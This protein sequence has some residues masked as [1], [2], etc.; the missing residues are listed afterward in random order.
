M[1]F[2]IITIFV[3][4]I[5]FSLL[6]ER[7]IKDRLPVYLIIGLLLVLVSAFKVVGVDPDSDNYEYTFLHYDASKSFFSIE[8][9]YIFLSWVVHFFTDDVHG[10]FL[11]YA[12]M[13]VGI[14]LYAIPKFTNLWFLPVAMYI[15]YYYVA[16]ECMQIRTGVLSGMFLLAIIAQG[17]GN[18]RKAFLFLL[19][20]T[21]FH[22]SGIILFLMLL[23]SNKQM[24]KKQRTKWML[25]IP[26]AYLLYLF[27]FSFLFNGTLNI[28]YISDRIALYQSATEKGIGNFASVNVFSPFQLLTVFLYYY[29]MYFYET[30]EKFN[31]YFP[32]LM[33]LLNLGIFFY[34]AFAFFPV[35]AQRV[36]MLYETVCIIVY[37]NIYYTLKP[38]WASISIIF[39]IGLLFLNYSLPYLGIDLF[40][41]V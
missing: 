21:L 24:T 23:L 41:K 31:P 25:V 7:M 18:K 8:Y 11:I 29:L 38:R 9:S 20:G 22:Y 26:I 6:E 15:S 3:I 12:L 30:I 36:S 28:P 17:D 40:W 27:G 2:F 16:H 37:T 14:K 13:G 34:V 1:G 5:F 33:K 32:L 19:I 39:L 4:S 35:L 10:L